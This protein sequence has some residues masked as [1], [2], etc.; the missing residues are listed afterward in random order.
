[1]SDNSTPYNAS[2]YEREVFR[3][4]PF[5][6]F[7]HTETID[8]VRTL[9]PDPS[10][11]LDTGCG[12]GYLAEQAL[13]LLPKT[14]FL[15]ADPAPAMLDRA[16]FRLSR[17][18]SDRIGF[19]GTLA[20][21]ELAGAV[22]ETPR[23]ISAIQCHHY[24]G[25]EAR[26]R[27]TDVCF[28]L[29]EKGGLYVTFENIRPATLRGVEIGLD[30]WSNFQTEAGRSQEAVDEHRARFGKNYFPITVAQHLELLKSAGFSTV[31]I[32]WLSQMQAGFYAI[33]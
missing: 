13:P 28:R 27:A 11:W 6:R 16:R 20:T 2:D 5:Y 8:L 10:V 4:I 7:F 31:E 21:E 30:R 3:T 1:M 17:F 26:R 23:V 19:L 25:D 22:P 12:T 32:F 33:K 9:L 18:P 15:L 24:G 29:L 14:R